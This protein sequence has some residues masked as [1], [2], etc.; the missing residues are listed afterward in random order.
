M[1]LV[2][3]DCGL[4]RSEFDCAFIES[5][6]IRPDGRGSA[7]NPL[8]L[9]PKLDP[10]PDNLMSH[11]A[12]G[13]LARLPLAIR[14]PPKC[15]AY[16]SANTSIANDSGTVVDLD[17]ERYDNDTMHSAVTNTSRITFNT[18]GLYVVTFVASFAANAAGDRSA[19]IR[20]NGSEFLAMNQKKAV[21]SATVETG[22]G[23]SVQAMFDAGEFVEAMVQQDSGGALN[24]LATRYS[25]IL[26]VRYRRRAA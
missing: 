20:K 4:E 14:T 3:P 16:A 26:S 23:V 22:L 10:D 25:P 13:L 11:G 2:C 12:S 9:I 19:F 5:D 24:L 1:S 15:Q 6:C 7:L 8:K 21:N 18:A 17:S